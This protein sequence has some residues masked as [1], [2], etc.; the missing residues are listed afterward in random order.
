MGQARRRGSYE[1]RVEE[2]IVKNIEKERQRDIKR[3]A[4]NRERLAYIDSLPP[5]ERQRHREGSAW[6]NSLMAI[7]AGLQASL[8]TR[9]DPR[10]NREPTLEELEDMLR[11]S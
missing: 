6:F 8:M 5:E 3:L 10:T 11:R 7:S 1:K 2:G 4:R 9:R